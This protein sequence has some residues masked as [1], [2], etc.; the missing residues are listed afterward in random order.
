VQLE[1]ASAQEAGA[2]DCPST[3]WISAEVEP[4]IKRNQAQIQFG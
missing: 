1:A 2:L 3:I 4:V